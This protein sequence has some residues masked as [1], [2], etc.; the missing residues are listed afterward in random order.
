VHRK[1]PVGAHSVKHDRVTSPAAFPTTHWSAVS[2]AAGT[3]EAAGRPH[4]NLLLG[5]YLPALRAHLV[6]GRRL[7]N[8][9]ADDVLQGF[10]ASKLLEQDLLAAADR[11]RGR[12]RSFLLTSLDRYLVDRIRHESV[13]G[14]RVSTGCAPNDDDGGPLDVAQSSAPAVDQAFDITWAREVLDETL[15]RA[16]QRLQHSG[17]QDV[18]DVFE[19]R[20]L[21]PIFDGTPAPPYRDV[22]QRFG[23]KTATEAC[24]AIVTAR[25]T[26]A[27]ALRE[28]IAEYA[29]DD[30]SIDEEVRD[31]RRILS[32]VR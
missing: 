3:T 9:Q 21:R 25:R 6:Q 17:R 31:L 26:F 13:R 28:V 5:R 10:V 15:R 30:A 4:L 27:S 14:R 7:A 24:T 8:D 19:C 23:Y 11:T 1:L 16:C 29:S 12:F 32:A 22:A 2:R 18:W 20:M